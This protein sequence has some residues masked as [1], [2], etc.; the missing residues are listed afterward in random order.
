[1]NIHSNSVGFDR[2]CCKGDFYGFIELKSLKLMTIDYISV[3]ISQSHL[4]SM[5]QKYWR[6]LFF[7]LKS[8]NIVITQDNEYFH[9]YRICWWYCR[10]EKKRRFARNNQYRPPWHKPARILRTINNRGH[11]MRTKKAK[12][13]SENAIFYRETLPG[14]AKSR[15]DSNSLSVSNEFVNYPI[16]NLPFW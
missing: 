2:F 9:S 1:M 8:P 4:E 14:K 15:S 10:K 3:N 13:H 5:E 12:S 6:L 7:L 16:I 11:L